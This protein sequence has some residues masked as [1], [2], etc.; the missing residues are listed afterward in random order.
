[1]SFNRRLDLMQEVRRHAARLDFLHAGQ[2][3]DENLDSRILEQETARIY[4]RWGIAKVEGLRIDGDIATPE[5]LLDSGPE[6]L[7]KEALSAIIEQIGLREEERK[8]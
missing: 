5:N 2:T 3:P 1:M 8:N 4:L 7:V 6:S